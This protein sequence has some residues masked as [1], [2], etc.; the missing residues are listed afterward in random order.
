MSSQGTSPAG[1]AGRT[2]T[3][4]QFTSTILIYFTLFILTITCT[5]CNET[6][7]EPCTGDYDVGAIEGTISIA[8]QPANTAI[9]IRPFDGPQKGKQIQIIQ[10]D[11][12]GY[13]RGD[14]P[15]GLYRLYVPPKESVTISPMR[16]EDSVS[17]GTDISRLDIQRTRFHVFISFPDML[18]GTICNAVLDGPERITMDELISNGEADFIAPIIPAGDYRFY[19]TLRTDRFWFPGTFDESLA[20]VY[21]ATT[22]DSIYMSKS[23]EDYATI[24]GSVTGSWQQVEIDKPMVTAFTTDSVL[25]STTTTNSSGDFLIELFDPQP[26]K[27]LVDIGGITNWIGGE[28]FLEATEYDVRSGEELTGITHVESGIS[29]QLFAYGQIDINVV[30]AIL[31]NETG[32]VYRP[33]EFWHQE[34]AISNLPSGSYRLYVYGYCREQTWAAQWYDGASDM[35]S[36]TPIILGEN[37]RAQISI[38]LVPGGRIEGDLTRHNGRETNF[39]RIFLYTPSGELL[40]PTGAYTNNSYFRISGLGNGDYLIATEDDYEEI[41]FYPG[42]TDIDSAA[43]ISIVDYGTASDI[44]WS[45]RRPPTR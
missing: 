34:V 32:K 6:T 45:L 35:A 38:D 10:S 20:E 26:V 25:V 39:A 8:G 28:T 18:N 1:V 23:L 29:C 42:T 5:S 43:V 4:A 37:E 22:S 30:S 41:W 9:G 16:Y 33:D 40:C 27:L 13:F 19:I 36:A 24:S 14:L 31:V 17:V 21:T 11:N 2:N 3:S 44:D 12:A 15:N 7:Y